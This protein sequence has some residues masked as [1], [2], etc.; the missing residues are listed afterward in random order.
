MNLYLAYSCNAWAQ[1]TY[2]EI[3]WPK[4]DLGLLISFPYLDTARLELF[5][6]CPRLMLDSGAFSAWNSGKVID[7]ARLTA[8]ARRKRWGS[9]VS[10]DVI[11][12][13]QRSKLNAWRM[14]QAVGGHVMPVF[15]IGEPL[16]LLRD[17]CAAFGVVGLSCRFGETIA[18]SLKWLDDCYRQSYPHR[19]HSFGWLA[20]DALRRFPFYSGDAVTWAMVPPTFGRWIKMGMLRTRAK[21]S[22]LAQV[23]AVAEQQA[24]LRARWAKELAR[25]TN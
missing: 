3:D 25:W 5:E 1:A 8:E 17:Y 20:N 2:R 10:L 19:F 16:A 21:V 18:E 22:L 12:D 13:W 11:G 24:F 7:F 15:H 6:K 4:F 14:R 23:H 9:V